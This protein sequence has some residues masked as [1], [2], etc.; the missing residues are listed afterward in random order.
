MTG[1]KNQGLLPYFNPFPHAGTTGDTLGSFSTA[2]DNSLL[3]SQFGLVLNVDTAIDQVLFDAAY[4]P[5]G[6]TVPAAT[7]EQLGRLRNILESVAGELRGDSYGV[8]TSIWN[9]SPNFVQGPNS[10]DDI[11]NTQ[12]SGTDQRYYIVFGPDAEV[13]NITLQLSVTGS[14]VNNANV[15]GDI[16][17]G[18][19]SG[20]LLINVPEAGG[21]FGPIDDGT[22][23]QNIATA[24]DGGLGNIWPATQA[25]TETFSANVRE[26][27]QQ[28]YDARTGTDWDFPIGM[29]SEVEVDGNRLRRQGRARCL[30]RM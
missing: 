3:Y 12:R 20:P 16:G 24:L 7:D 17:G 9:A 5:A 13:G 19:N 15:V 11:V 14:I 23:E 30:T 25:N 10:S 27:T 26:V 28:E 6:S 21:Q 29:P 22:V 18:F 4:P 2:A 8:M 1:G